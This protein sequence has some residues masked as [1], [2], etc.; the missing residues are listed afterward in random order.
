MKAVFP[1]L[2]VMVL[3]YQPARV[4]EQRTFCGRTVEGWTEILR[5]KAGTADG[6]PQAVLALAHVWGGAT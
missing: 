1:P 4:D 2:L 6:R 3:W 5:D